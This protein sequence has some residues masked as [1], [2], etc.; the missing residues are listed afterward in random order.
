VRLFV[1]PLVAIKGVVK[2]TLGEP[3]GN[4]LFGGLDSV[5]AVADVHADLDGEV[6]TDGAGGGV[7]GV[8]LA[9]HLAAGLDGTLANP[10]HAA[11]GAGEHVLDQ[12]G[13]EG[14]LGEVSV[15]LKRERERERERKE[16]G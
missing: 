8:G 3:E 10:D 13:E 4:L 16:R 12:L 5:R 9:E 11:D 14:A 15:V 7:G 1:N 2:N 6:A